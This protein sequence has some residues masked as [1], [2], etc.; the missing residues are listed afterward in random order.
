M[1][2]IFITLCL[3][4]SILG[5]SAEIENDSTIKNVED[6]DEKQ[7]LPCTEMWSNDVDCLMTD[8]CA[9]FEEACII[10]DRA[11]EQCLDD[12]YGN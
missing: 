2:K 8:Y 6:N 7:Y 11:F 3:L 1:K 10:A 9:T 5:F 12:M 4:G